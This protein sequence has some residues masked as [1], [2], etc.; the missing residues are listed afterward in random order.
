[1]WELAVSVPSFSARLRENAIVELQK[2]NAKKPWTV[3]FAFSFKEN[4]P[5]STDIEWWIQVHVT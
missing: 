1:M 5:W 3:A 4:A 2:S